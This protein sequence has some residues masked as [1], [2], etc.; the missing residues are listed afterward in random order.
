MEYFLT[1]SGNFGVEWNPDLTLTVNIVLITEFATYIILGSFQALSLLQCTTVHIV[2]GSQTPRWHCP[3]VCY[4]LVLRQDS[5]CYQQG[6]PFLKFLHSLL[7]IS[8][9]SKTA[10]IKTFKYKHKDM[11]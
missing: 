5:A 2:N 9:S 7:V 6:Q 8:Q 1:Q 4:M 11:S 3:S 10:K